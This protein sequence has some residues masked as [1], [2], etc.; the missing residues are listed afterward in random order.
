MVTNAYVATEWSLWRPHPS[1]DFTLGVEEEVMMLNAHDWSLAQQVDRVLMSLP[2]RL[3]LQVKP[4][5]HKATLEIGSSVHTTV[6]NVEAELRELRG[7]VDLQLALLGLRAA[8]AG[9]PPMT[10]L[11]RAGGGGRHPSDDCLAR[12][13]GLE[14]R[15][16]ARGLRVDARARAPG[17]DLRPSRA[18]GD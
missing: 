8:A 17:A 16:A 13:G 10:F 6:R 12:V 9:T 18:R 1:E 7:S 4:E 14:R 5:T 3:A 15:P 2:S 11:A